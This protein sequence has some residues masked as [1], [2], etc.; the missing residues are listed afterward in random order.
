MIR[1]RCF[2]RRVRHRRIVFLNRLAVVEGAFHNPLVAWEWVAPVATA[3]AT[4]TVGVAGIF[5]TWLTGKQSRDHA[6]E[7]LEEQLGHERLQAREAREQE[8][9]ENAY[10]ELL[11]M[12]ER[13]GQWAQMVYPMVETGPLPETPLPTLEVQ[14]DTAALQAAFGTDRVRQLTE[15]WEAVVKLM[16]RQAELVVW[17]EQHPPGPGDPRLQRPYENSPRAVVLRLRPEEKKTRDELGAQVR[18]EL[19][20]LYRS[21]AR[22]TGVTRSYTYENGTLIERLESAALEGAARPQGDRPPEQTPEI[23]GQST[24]PRSQ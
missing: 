7:T 22:P 15:T 16:I 23:P 13:V 24:P 19:R 18:A 8:R 14:A 21:S 20:F 4:T 3:A 1:W 5:F 17:E 6:Q 2:Y 11:K 12:A 10:L 9:L